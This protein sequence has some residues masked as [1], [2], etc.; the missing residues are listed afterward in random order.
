MPEDWLSALLPLVACAECSSEEK[1]RTGA[2]EEQQRLVASLG[3]KR[4]QLRA[5]KRRI[6][7]PDYKVRAKAEVDV[8]Q[9][10]A[11]VREAAEALNDFRN[12]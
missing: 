11:H 3:L 5:A 8:D 10:E 6:H 9:L 4:Q 1:G 2:T 7:D 12:K